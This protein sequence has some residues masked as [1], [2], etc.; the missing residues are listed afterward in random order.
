MKLK[1]TS[2]F[3]VALGSIMLNFTNLNQTVNATENKS[4]LQ[5]SFTIDIN[6]VNNRDNFKKQ[7]SQFKKQ[8]E[9]LPTDEQT[10]QFNNFLKLIEEDFG[11]KIINQNL[12]N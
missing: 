7:I 12:K 11:V 4:K 10:E 9:E 3:F 2:L 8:L 6:D 1:L 5:F